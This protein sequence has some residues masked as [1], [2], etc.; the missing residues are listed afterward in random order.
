MT[1]IYR[2]FWVVSGRAA[3]KHVIHS[4]IPCVRHRAAC[5]QPMMAGPQAAPHFGGLW[6]A[7]I[8]SAKTHLKRVIGTQILTM[9]EMMTLTVS[10]EGILNSRPLTTLSIKK[11]YSSSNDSTSLTPGNFLIG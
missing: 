9:E 4:C 2:K 8:K 11:I 6:E 3:I 7:A 1:M 5:P 10:I